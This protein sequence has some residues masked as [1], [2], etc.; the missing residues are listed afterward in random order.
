MAS[1]RALVV[2]VVAVSFLPASAY[3]VAMQRTAS[4]REMGVHERLEARLQH[5]ARPTSSPS[6]PQALPTRS[7]GVGGDMP[8]FNVMD[9]GAKGDST[10]D[11]TKAFQA[12]LNAASA[13]T[14]GEVFAPAGGLVCRKAAGNL[15]FMLTRNWLHCAF[16]A[17]SLCIHC[18]YTVHT[19]CIHRVHT[20]CIHCAYTVHTQL[21]A[22]RQPHHIS[23]HHKPYQ[24]K[25]QP[26]IFP[27]I[28]SIPAY[29]YCTEQHI[30]TLTAMHLNNH[31]AYLAPSSSTSAASYLQV[32]VRREHSRARGS[33][34]AGILSVCAVARLPLWRPTYRWHGTEATGWPG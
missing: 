28:C 33:G 13:A 30:I 6:Q 25:P 14:G 16:T 8:V 20:L 26:H 31:I 32:R 23:L 18:A 1:Y 11:N 2:V 7:A 9:Y 15:L 10:T 17:H 12:A 5:R 3:V 29:P 34:T 24:N 19:L 4:W 27:T 21:H 22:H